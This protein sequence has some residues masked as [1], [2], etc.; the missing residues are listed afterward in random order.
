MREKLFRGIAAV[1]VG[2]F[3]RLSPRTAARIG[4][5][6]GDI[7][8]FIDKEHRDISNRNLRLAYGQALS[9]KQIRR[10]TREV[11]RNFSRL[12]TEFIQIPSLTYEKALRFI[13]PENRERLDTC[14]KRGKGVIL[15]TGHLGNWELMAAV[16]VMAG[17]PISAIARPMND[18][19]WNRIINDIRSSSGLKVIARNR[20]AFAIVKRLKRNEVVGILADQNTRKQNVF[21]DFFGVTAASTPGPALLAL[22]T[23]ASLVPTFM[24]R[25]GLANHRLIIEEPIEVVPTG[26]TEADAVAITQKYASI[27]ERYVRQYPTQ[28]FWLHR[29]WRTRPPGEPQ[30]YEK[31]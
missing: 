14:L 18:S 11:F 3:G 19:I 22:K 28:W 1:F 20:S 10:M 7:G 9:E 26:D 17:Y 29:R 5:I 27:L 16:G 2:L 15:V 25:E 4:T 21:V 13:T 12:A 31:R 6:I 8:Y 30:L 23:G 24:V